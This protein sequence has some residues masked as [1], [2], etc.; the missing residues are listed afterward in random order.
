MSTDS[1]SFNRNPPPSRHR[2]ARVGLGDRIREWWFPI[3][4]WEL[5]G[6]LWEVLGI[7][8]LYVLTAHMA[9]EVVLPDLRGGATELSP[10]SVEEI[11][12]RSRYHE[13]ANVVLFM[14][15]F[16][17][18][19]AGVLIGN[20]SFFLLHAILAGVNA[21]CVLIER[22]KRSLALR[23][24]SDGQ[25]GVQPIPSVRAPEKP[26]GDWYF[27]P[28]RW[29]SEALYQRLGVA[30]FKEMLVD[31]VTA[32]RYPPEERTTNAKFMEGNSLEDLLGLERTT[33]ISESIH[34]AAFLGRLGMAIAFWGIEFGIDLYFLVFLIL[35]LYFVLV[36][37]YHRLRV[38]K[39]VQRYRTRRGARVTGEAPAGSST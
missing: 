21:S 19:V 32:C 39:V 28:K 16:P 31:G 38:W 18:L 26:S 27:A 24:Q 20:L 8:R 4:G 10:E 37:R 2:R 25:M 11:R 23:L 36:Q 29:E 35:D 22:Y 9:G 7:R 15:Y 13:W 17:G 34:L 1:K 14:T 30:R 33:R 5:K 12:R 3:R 6:R